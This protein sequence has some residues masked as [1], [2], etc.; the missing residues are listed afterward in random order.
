LGTRDD[1]KTVVGKYR[2]KNPL[3]RLRRKSNVNT[4]FREKRCEDLSRTGKD[5]V[6]W[7]RLMVFGFYHK[8]ELL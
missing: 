6:Q 7:W 5:E 4:E 1:Y 3:E 2:K 8:G